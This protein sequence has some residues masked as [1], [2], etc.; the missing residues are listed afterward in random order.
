MAVTLGELDIRVL[1]WM[2]V[3]VTLGELD[4]RVL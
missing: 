2:Y 3:A 4:I 1:Y